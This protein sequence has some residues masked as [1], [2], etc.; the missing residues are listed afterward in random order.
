V[1][2][3]SATAETK[4]IKLTVYRFNPETDAEPRYETYE[5]EWLP[6]LTAIMALTYINKHSRANI[7]FRR[8]CREAGCGACTISVNGVPALACRALAQDGDVLEP[9]KG[10]PVIRDLVIDRTQ[11]TAEMFRKIK[12][13]REGKPIGFIPAKPEAIGVSRALTICADCHGCNSICPPWLESP[14]RFVGPMYLANIIRAMFN[15]L[16]EYDRVAQAV[17]MGLY[18]CTLCR[19][20]TTSCPKDIEITESMI[21][22]RQRAVE[23]DVLPEE[24]REIRRNILETDS[25]YG[26]C[27]KERASWATDLGIP[28]SGKTLF[29]ASCEYSATEGGRAV[30]ARAAELLQKA[31]SSLSYLY[32]EE[33]CCGAPLYFYGFQKE[34]REK[35]AKV[36][37]LLKETGV[38]EIITPSPAC[39]YTFRELYPKYA[40]DSNIQVRTVLEVILEKIRSKAISLKAMGNRKVVFHDPAFLS[41][42]LGMVEEPRE[43]LASIPGISLVEPKYYWGAN[44]MGDGGLGASEEVNSKIAQARLR[45]LAE[46]GAETIVTASAADSARLK[47]AAQALG[48]ED[49]EIVDLIELVA[50]ALEV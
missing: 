25:L 1:T 29:F 21:L 4:T 2:I 17:D 49:M 26:V 19:A 37:K 13:G 48:R 6:S 3:V 35:A 44:T 47:Q 33:Q 9:L 40:G 12:Y 16:E 10:Y 22:A 30:L 20:C 31:G 42:F 39:A 46:G 34:F 36:Q 7:A 32:E 23:E 28:K 18:N 45:Q 50:R 41:R 15:P 27:G 38:E 14:A 8:G 43:I 5:A 24:V 11:Q